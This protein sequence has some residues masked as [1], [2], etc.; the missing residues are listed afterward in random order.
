MS[1][2]A[3]PSL[4]DAVPLARVGLFDRTKAP[5]PGDSAVTGQSR[6]FDA[7]LAST[8]GHARKADAIWEEQHEAR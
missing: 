5:K 3:I 1:Q 8:P 2:G 6:D 4:Y 7:K